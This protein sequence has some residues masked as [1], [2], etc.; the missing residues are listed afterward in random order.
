MAFAAA[1]QAVVSLTSA[2]TALATLDS[3]VHAA[4]GLVV[5]GNAT[6]TSAERDNNLATLSEAGTVA[7]VMAALALSSAALGSALAAGELWAET[8]VAALT[9]LESGNATASFS[10]FTG[11]KGLLILSAIS[12]RAAIQAALALNPV[13]SVPATTLAPAINATV[14]TL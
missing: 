10:A 3:V 2:A 13:M 7:V 6:D 4:L 8:V 11:D 1:E 14:E 12:L 9:Q 5:A